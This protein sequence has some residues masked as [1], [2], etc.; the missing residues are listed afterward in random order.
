MLFVGAAAGRSEVEVADSR[1]AGC[2]SLQDMGSA[3]AVVIEEEVAVAVGG[4]AVPD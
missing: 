4:E 3:A 2:S 1:A